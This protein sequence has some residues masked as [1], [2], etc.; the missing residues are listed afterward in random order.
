MDHTICPGSKYLRQPKPEEKKCQNC[1]YEI[2][3]WTDELRAT[4]PQC[5]KFVMKD[6][7][8]SCLEWCAM[9]KEC[10]GEAIY[11][12]FMK[13]KEV[14]IRE[15]LIRELEKWFGDDSKRIN[16]AKEVL[17]FALELAK[18]ESADWHIVVPSAIL[19]DVGIKVAEEKYGSNAGN[20]QE[21]EGPPV[22]RK[23]LLRAGI[24]INDI[25]Q[26]C[27]IIGH[28]HSPGKITTINFKVLYDADCMV[29]IREIVG[30]KSKEDF[31]RIIGKMFLTGSGR[32][33]AKEVYL[34]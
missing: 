8:M 14:S 7:T 26:I 27:E 1:G 15:T 31:E 28:H 16:H 3:I 33:K 10:V 32:K 20:Y 34:E 6:G 17:K 13:N 5:G 2:E 29:N 19:H 21:K 30:K 22:A 25:D 11:D 24:K 23:M 9:G 4:C 12:K 18:E